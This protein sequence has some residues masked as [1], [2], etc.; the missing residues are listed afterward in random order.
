MES[1]HRYW[2][3]SIE[4]KEIYQHLSKTM[5]QLGMISYNFNPSTQKS[6]VVKC[7]EYKEHSMQVRATVYDTIYKEKNKVNK[8]I[9]N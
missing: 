3:D 1:K 8:K 2:W 7:L 4:N 9:K 5:L 6:E